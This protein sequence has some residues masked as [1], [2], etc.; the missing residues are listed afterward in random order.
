[1]NSLLRRDE[2]SWV[3]VVLMP[4]TLPLDL[5]VY[6]LTARE[7]DPVSVLLFFGAREIQMLKRS[8]ETFESA[9]ASFSSGAP[10]MVQTIVA[11]IQYFHDC[12]DQAKREEEKNRVTR[13][14]SY[15]AVPPGEH[16]DD[17]Y[18]EDYGSYALD[19]QISILISSVSVKDH[20]RL[21]R[22]PMQT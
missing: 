9:F 8:E 2:L 7:L 11:N 6:T 5:G 17:E 16:L 15:A 12:A 13:N 10:P 21:V 19:H 3:L 4:Q 22:W 18:E 1:M 20:S 14:F